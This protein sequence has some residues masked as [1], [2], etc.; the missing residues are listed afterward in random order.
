MVI[1]K[2]TKITYKYKYIQVQVEIAYTP[3]SGKALFL[4]LFLN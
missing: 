2:P 1:T 4:E 3:P